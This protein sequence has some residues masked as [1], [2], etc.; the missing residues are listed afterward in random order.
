M[1]VT[2]PCSGP[3]RCH[4]AHGG[5]GTVLVERWT[6]GIL[7]VALMWL[8]KE[9]ISLS[10]HPVRR[11]LRCLSRLPPLVDLPQKHRDAQPFACGLAW[12]ELMLALR[13][14]STLA[15]MLRLGVSEEARAQEHGMLTILLPQRVHTLI[16]M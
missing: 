7:D 2:L 6:P 8:G 16:Q 11:A 4:G 9:M 5:V 3:N 13:Q 14:M 12:Q 1:V 10:P 15:V